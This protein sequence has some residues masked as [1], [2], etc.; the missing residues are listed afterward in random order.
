LDSD[1]CRLE[2]VDAGGCNSLGT[3]GGGELNCDIGDIGGG[4]YAVSPG[5]GNAAAG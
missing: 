5:W 2:F 4:G 1:L 3:G